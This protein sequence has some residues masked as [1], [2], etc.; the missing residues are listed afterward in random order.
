MTE[1]EMLEKIMKQN[2]EILKVNDSKPKEDTALMKKKKSHKTS[3]VKRWIRLFDDCNPMDINDFAVEEAKKV[4]LPNHSYVTTSQR[5]KTMNELDLRSLEYWATRN[6]KDV[7]AWTLNIP[8]QIVLT[9][10]LIEQWIKEGID[11]DRIESMLKT[12]EDKDEC[13]PN[14][15][16][17]NSLI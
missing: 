13:Y 8:A 9:T 14:A 1:K 7:R 12:N 2:E 16:N 17:L 15:Q 3:S 5:G 6:P 11:E 4:I 10:K